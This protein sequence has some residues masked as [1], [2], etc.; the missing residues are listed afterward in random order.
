MLEKQISVTL[1]TDSDGHLPRKCPH[2]NAYFAV[3]AEEYERRAHLNLRC[4]TCKWIFASDD[5]TTPEQLEYARAATATEARRMASDLVNDA[6]EELFKGFRNNKHVKI[7]RSGKG[8]DFG[9]EEL[10]NPHPPVQLSPTPRCAACQFAYK[11]QDGTGACPVC[12]D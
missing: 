10:P 8:I 12:R 6:F 4:P 7:E 1:P 11:T 2:C 9:A 5:G 3:H